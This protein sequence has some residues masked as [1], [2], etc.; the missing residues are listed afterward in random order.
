MKKLLL[1]LS[2]IAGV[3]ALAQTV[4]GLVRERTFKTL[5]NSNLNASTIRVTSG[6]LGL[7]R[8]A[9]FNV[10][11]INTNSAIVDRIAVTLSRPE[12]RQWMNSTNPA[13]VLKT[14]IISKLAVQEDPSE[15]LTDPSE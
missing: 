8:V 15:Q 12:L 14:I 11:L 6:E 9:V 13:A 7:N 4:P 2:A 1:I 10:E 5:P 3:A